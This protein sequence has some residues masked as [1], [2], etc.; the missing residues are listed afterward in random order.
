MSAAERRI[1]IVSQNVSNIS[2][3]GYKRKTAFLDLVSAETANNLTSNHITLRTN[4]TQGKLLSTGNRL[5]IAISGDAMFAVRAGDRILYTRQGQFERNADGAVV[6][7]QGHVLQQTGGGDLIL[8]SAQVSIADDGTVLDG[9]RPIARIALSTTDDKAT[10]VPEGD[11]SFAAPAVAM[12]DAE[13]AIVRPGMVEA[14]N[15]TLG[16]EMLHSMGAVR[17]AERGARLAQTWDDL[18]GRVITTLGQSR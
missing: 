13:G 3:P 1:T 17:D 15:V 12:R 18:M 6:T 7:P 11:S 2:T 14:S 10:L 9:D 5:D 8:E 4:F 16:D